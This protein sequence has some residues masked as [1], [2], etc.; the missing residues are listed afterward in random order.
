MNGRTSHRVLV[1]VDSIDL[2]A[3]ETLRYARG[4]TADRLLAV[5]FVLDEARAVRLQVRWQ[6][7]GAGTELRMV[8]CDDRRLGRAA[9]RFVVQVRK[10]YPNSAVTV[11]LPRRM[12]SPLAGRLLHDR[13]A[14]ALAGLLSGIPGVSAQI[15][16]CDV[17]SQ[18]A[19]TLQ[20]AGR[21]VPAAQAE[22]AGK[23]QASASRPERSPAPAELR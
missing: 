16:V 5:H 1:F 22:F 23:L 17:K 11:L 2:V 20:S 10:D 14:D 18:V 19:R 8:D 21:E 12:Y 6:R 13:T 15:L 9:Q 7:F 4:L 3:V